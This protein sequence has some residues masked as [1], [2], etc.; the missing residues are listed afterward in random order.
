MTTYPLYV[1]SGP[2]HRTTMVH[3]LDLLGCIANGPTTEAALAATPGAIRAWRALLTRHGEAADP[4]APFDTTVVA[5]VTEGSWIGYGDPYP[6]FA[7]DF[8]PIE[9]DEAAL[10]VQHYRWLRADLLALV[11]NL[12]PE[13]VVAEPAGGW[14]I[15]KLLHHVA[16]ANTAYLQ[17]PVQ[18]TPVLAALSKRLPDGDGDPLALMA[19][20]AELVAQRLLAMTPDERSAQVAHGQKL[21]TARRALRRCLEHE[22]EHLMELS[23]RLGQPPAS[24]AL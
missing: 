7:P 12:R 22:W 4:A 17:T 10:H 5:H 2:K 3:V 24:D 19:E 23:R 6:G 15:A 13:Q 16:R 8:T 14:S 1:E 11:R 9:P 20:Q 18:R 21:W